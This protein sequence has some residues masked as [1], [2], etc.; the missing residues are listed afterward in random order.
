M[1]SC[2][3]L[4][5]FL[6]HQLRPEVPGADG[7]PARTRP[8]APPRPSGP[9]GDAPL[10]PQQAEQRGGRASTVQTRVSPAPSWSFIVGLPWR[11]GWDS[12]KAYAGPTAQSERRGERDDANAASGTPD[13]HWLRRMRRLSTRRSREPGRRRRVRQVSG[14]RATRTPADLDR[15]ER[16][17]SARPRQRQRGAEGLSSAPGPQQRPDDPQHAG[18]GAC[19]ASRSGV[20]HAVWRHGSSTTPSLAA[21]APGARELAVVG[22]P[23]AARGRAPSAR[24]PARGRCSTF[25]RGVGGGRVQVEARPAPDLVER[26]RHADVL[27]AVR[28]LQPRDERARPEVVRPPGVG[29]LLG[30]GRHQPHVA[31]GLRPGGERAGERDERPDARR[32]VVR[33]GRGRNGVRVRHRDHQAV[34]RRVPDPDHVA[35]RAPCRARVNRSYPTRSP[36]AR[37]R[38]ATR[39]CALPLGRRPGGPRPLPRER[40]RERVRLAPARRAAAARATQNGTKHA[41]EFATTRVLF[42]RGTPREGSAMPPRDPSFTTIG[43]S[44]GLS[45]GTTRGTRWVGRGSRTIDGRAASRRSR[46]SDKRVEAGRLLLLTGVFTP[47]GHP[48]ISL[49]GRC[50]AA[51]KACGA[52]AVL[53]HYAAAFLWGDARTL[54]LPPDITAPT[55]KNHPGINTPAPDP[56]TPRPSTASRSPRRCRPSFTCRRSCRSR[57]SAAPSTKH[58]AEASSPRSTRHLA[59]PRREEAP[60]GPR[61]GR[62][63]PFRE[64]ESRP[65]LLDA[66]DRQAPGQPRSA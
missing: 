39:W 57:P 29:P 15:P 27:E 38:A 42:R 16:R 41:D 53:S 58:S 31:R 14:G 5:V 21:G 23:L 51:V 63:D 61:H 33:P 8:S 65:A 2:R 24:R 17:G 40:H 7:S 46:R 43:C 11:R 12:R 66:A 18:E 35:R 19:A 48:T 56:S 32:V 37:N 20:S 62:S 13:Q 45:R 44:S 60:T 55:N 1:D 30:A 52:G 47:S 36:T 6:P 50:L 64:R 22:V 54:R 25:S 3:L 4:P 49:R 59:P 28:A 34:A 9:S 26:E 10:R